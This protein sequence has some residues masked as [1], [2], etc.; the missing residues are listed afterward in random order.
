MDKTSAKIDSAKIENCRFSVMCNRRWEDLAEIKDAP[1]I[2]YCSKC[3]HS[4][5][6]CTLVD[7]LDHAEKGHCVALIDSA[8]EEKEESA[9][10]KLVGLVD[11]ESM[12][13]PYR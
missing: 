9:Q 1:G 8:D 2:R 7:F 13:A 3:D 4:V 6:L 11:I 5:H 12:R 10:R